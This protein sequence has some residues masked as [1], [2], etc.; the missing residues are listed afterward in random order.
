MIGR[1]KIL[2]Q[3]LF[4]GCATKIGYYHFPDTIYHIIDYNIIKVV[5]YNPVPNEIDFIRFKKSI[6]VINADFCHLF[7]LLL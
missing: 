3:K 2:Y 5:G 6:T 7:N 1:L 4:V